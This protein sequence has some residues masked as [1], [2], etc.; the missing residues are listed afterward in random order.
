MIRRHPAPAPATDPNHPVLLN[1][2]EV[3]ELTR[4]PKS[5]LHAW[6]AARDA[7]ELVDAPRH[8]AMS[9]HRR[10]WAESDVYAWLESRHR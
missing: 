10:L 4:I 9:P 5:T 6:A 3:E 7:G 8:F 1:A 2:A